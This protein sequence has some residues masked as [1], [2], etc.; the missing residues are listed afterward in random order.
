MIKLTVCHFTSLAATGTIR[1]TWHDK[2]NQE[3]G[4]ETLQSR[5]WFQKLCLFY[6]SLLTCL[7]ICPVLI[8]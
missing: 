7:T 5:Q 4:L 6:N 3:L 1:G 2:L 8:E